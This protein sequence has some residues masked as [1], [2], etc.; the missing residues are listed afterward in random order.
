MKKAPAVTALLLI[1]GLLLLGPTATGGVPR[2][3]LVPPGW[4]GGVIPY[5]MDERLS[6][7]GKRSAGD[8]IA[9]W[10]EATV[11]RFVPRTDEPDYI[12]VVEHVE[13]YVV[14]GIAQ[15]CARQP[16]C[17]RVSGSLAN[18]AHGLGHAIGL[19]HEQ[20]RLDRDR[21]I[22]VFQQHISPHYRWTWNPRSFYGADI[23]PYNYQSVMHYGFLSSKRNRRGGPPALETIPPHMPVGQHTTPSDL[24]TPGDA[25]TVARMFGLTPTSWTV[26]TNPLGLTVIVDGEEVTTPAVFDWTPGSEHTLSVPPDPQVRPGSRYRFGRW[27]DADAAGTRTVTATSA[28]T[29]YDANFVAAHRISTR[30]RPEGAGTVTVSPGSSDG[31]HPLRSR[32]TVRAEPTAGSGFRFLRWEIRSDYGWQGL[33]TH[34]THGTSANPAHSY[35]MPGLEYT[36]IFTQGPIFRVES[37]ADP[38][39]VEIDGREYRTPV[40]IEARALPERAQ[41]SLAREW[42]EHDK[43]YRDRFRSWSDGGDEAHVVSVSRT[44]DTILKLTVDVERRLEARASTDWKGSVLTTP[45]AEDGFY[46]D[47]TE[48]RV[49]AVPIP[50]AKFVGWNG[51]VAG[52]DPTTSVVMDDGK[53]AEAVFVREAAELESGAATPVSLQWRGDDLDWAGYYVRTPPDANGLEV[54]FDTESATLGAE[55]G[56]WVTD[57]EMFPNW[58]RHQ[59]AHGVL[60]DGVATLGVGRPPDRRPT[61]WFILIRAAESDAAG[62]RTLEGT[63]VAT[64]T[65]DAIRNRAPQVVGTLENRTL[66]LG[67]GPLV[68]DVARAFSDPDGDVLTY[69]AVSSAPTIAAVVVSGDTV[70]VTPVRPGSAT[71]TVTAT[72]PGGASATQQFAVA[73]AARATFTDHPIVPGTTPIR[74]VHFTELRE[75]IA[76]LR[77]H[78]GLPAFPWTDPTL[79]A[80]VTPVKRVHLTELRSALAAV[81]DAAGQPRPGYAD[82]G[83]SA[84]TLPIKAAHIMEL[85]VA[86]LVVE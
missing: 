68:V 9:V 79:V 44:E 64:V 24:I 66:T 17:W 1:L 39:S 19:E 18:D 10:T 42:I 38:T 14:Q 56:L 11:L 43:G 26:S 67:G 13:E 84:R 78:H 80:G 49:R 41:V 32:V 25:D 23:S 86:V 46:P 31:Y 12:H 65:R 15:P 85:R 60:R 5:L 51:D 45:P 48:V 73:V 69:K 72:D 4:I 55:A 75:R 7:D 3:D 59:D 40:A 63:L 21:Y 35:A 22:R 54:R 52:R 27:S 50:P 58:V 6:D 83:A 74:A 36:A 77:A 30:V 29:L 57:R 2:W 20:Q 76:A 16:T 8:A 33:V 70:T 28:T 81:Y 71:V 34:E 61:A 37:N 53:R 82:A 47:G 62:T